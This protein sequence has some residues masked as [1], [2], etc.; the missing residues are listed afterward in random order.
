VRAWRVRILFETEA[1]WY[2]RRGWEPASTENV[3]R[4]E[5]DYVG[6]GYFNLKSVVRGPTFSRFM[7]PIRNAYYTGHVIAK[8][9]LRSPGPAF[10]R[11][12]R[13]HITHADRSLASGDYRSLRRVMKE[14]GSSPLSESDRGMEPLRAGR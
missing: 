9:L 6:G 1:H 11:N 8:D 4:G 3:A 13:E 5:R 12:L 2:R 10:L 7:W 14:I